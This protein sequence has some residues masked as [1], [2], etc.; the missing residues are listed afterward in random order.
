MRFFWIILDSALG[1][2]FLNRISNLRVTNTVVKKVISK[3]GMILTPRARKVIQEALPSHTQGVNGDDLQIGIVTRE[4]DSKYLDLCI[5]AIKLTHP[6]V[7][8]RIH[9][10]C[11]DEDFETLRHRVDEDVAIHC[12]SEYINS[13]IE[14]KLSCFD[15]NRR[16]WIRQQIIKVSF[17][18]RSENLYTLL[19]DSDTLL[20]KHQLWIDQEGKQL[21]AISQEYHSPYDIHFQRYFRDL[22]NRFPRKMRVSFVTHHQVMQRKILNELFSSN[23]TG[24]NT[25]GL[26]KWLNAID[27]KESSGACEWHTYASYLLSEHPDQVNLYRWLNTPVAPKKLDTLNLQNL[28]MTLNKIRLDYPLNNSISLHHYLR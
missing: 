19:V 7:S 17:A 23:K 13:E 15:L 20:L 10:V 3:Q 16:G 5:A 9:V 21:L 11:P 28:E 8:D 24:F 1:R 26:I 25:S 22:F 18:A 4:K 12:D 14:Q 27:P 2:I 6:E